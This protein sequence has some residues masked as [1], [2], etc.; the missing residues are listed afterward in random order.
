VAAYN[1]HWRIVQA[2][3]NTEG[4]DVSTIPS[5]RKPPLIVAA[6]M[7]YRDI[8]QLLIE[9]PDTNNADASTALLEAAINRHQAVVSLLLDHGTSPILMDVVEH[10]L[11]GLVKI[12]LSEGADPNFR[13]K[14]GRTP[15]SHAAELDHDDIVRLLLEYGAVPTAEDQYGRSPISWAAV[16][17]NCTIISLFLDNG[18]VSPNTMDANG[19]TVLWIAAEYGH[20]TLVEFLLTVDEIDLNLSDAKTGQTPLLRAVCFGYDAIVKLLLAAGDI[21]SDVADHDG[22]TP[23]WCAVA[24]GYETVVNLLLAHEGVDPHSMDSYFEKILL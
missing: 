2:L 19:Q 4:I 18:N 10:G 13:D 17:G 9:H 11:M 21:D 3:L 14:F 15:L 20:I 24:K 8:V 23:L 1:G 22:W 5:N 6:Q 7:G 12:S 16:R